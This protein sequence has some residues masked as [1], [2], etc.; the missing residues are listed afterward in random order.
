MSP[1]DRPLLLPIRGAIEGFYGAPFSHAERL[2]LLRFLGEHRYTCFV[3][4]PKNDPL[5]RER[6]REP[7]PGEEIARFRELAATAAG[8]RVRFVYAI[9]PGLTYDPATARDFVALSDK[10]AALV[11]AGA[12]GIALLFDDLTADSTMLDPIAQAELI[13]RV[14]DG[15]ARLDAGL[16]FW[17]IGNF[18]CGDVSEL[19][20]GGGFWGAQINILKI[21]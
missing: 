5:H 7:Y 4:A 13:A 16:D 18:Y 12:R 11:E 9:S 17:F 15:V 10:I 6:W 1:I 14:A 8:H 20:D 19:R 3:Y 2:E 21:P